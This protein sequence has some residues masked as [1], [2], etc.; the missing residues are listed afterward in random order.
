MFNSDGE[1]REN[2]GDAKEADVI[3][4]ILFIS[5]ALDGRILIIDNAEVY[6][7]GTTVMVTEFV[8]KS[9]YSNENLEDPIGE[10]KGVGYY[11]ENPT[12]PGIPNN[13]VQLINTDCADCA[14]LLKAFPNISSL[15]GTKFTNISCM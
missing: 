3:C 5:T 9:Y 13:Y 12:Y 11:Y 15:N 6:L 2:E 7:D 10:A 1:Q 4:G 8:Q 14:E